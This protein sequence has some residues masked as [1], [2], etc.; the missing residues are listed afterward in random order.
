MLLILFNVS[1]SIS[2][3]KLQ[4]MSEYLQGDSFK[5]KIKRNEM[6]FFLS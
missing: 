4:I 3:I 5:I 6:K 1:L 2:D